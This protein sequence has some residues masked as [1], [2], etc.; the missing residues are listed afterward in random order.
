[1]K[2]LMTRAT[3]LLVAVL[4][5]AACDD[6]FPPPV[7]SGPRVVAD[8]VA[9][10]QRDLW[11][12]P[13]EG[14]SP[15][16]LTNQPADDRMATVAGDL[17]VFSSSRTGSPRLHSMPL[18]GG[19]VRLLGPT[20]GTELN[21]ALSPDGAWIAFESDATGASKI[22]I[23]RADGSAPR[24]ITAGFGFEGSIESGPA[25]SPDGH[26]L[27]FSSTHAGPAAL[28][29]TDLATTGAITPL[30]DDGHPNLGPAWSP[31]GT[32]IAFTSE[33][34]GVIGVYLLT[35]ATGAVTPVAAGG[36]QAFQPAWIS[37]T[38]LVVVAEEGGVAQ[39]R[40][41]SLDSG[42]VEVVPVPG[43]GV[44]NPAVVLP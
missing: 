11:L 13:L 25:W 32:R 33:R 44:R 18:A 30:L 34:N 28:H 24:R 1:M 43:S 36:G 6:P 7:D 31:D 19:N 4:L 42:Q 14:G 29:L 15:R 5:L 39:L 12:I 35:L 23:A 10:G 37:N 27:A 3:P 8:L 9:A 41:V 21:P 38:E 40:V 17:V 22:W 2:Y 16:R 26:R 20:T